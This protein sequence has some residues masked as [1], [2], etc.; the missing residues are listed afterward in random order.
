M[1]LWLFIHSSII[2]GICVNEIFSFK[3]NSTAKS[4]DTFNTTGYDFLEFIASKA[5]FTHL[6]L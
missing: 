4:F 5:N 1:Q 3:N 6:N 2:S